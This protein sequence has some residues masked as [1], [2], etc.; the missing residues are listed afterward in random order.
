M[1]KQYFE[2]RLIGMSEEERILER[3]VDKKVKLIF[4]R[5]Y[6]IRKIRRRKMLNQWLK[7]HTN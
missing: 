5:A 1:N 6:K 3:E 7:G 2:M 4:K